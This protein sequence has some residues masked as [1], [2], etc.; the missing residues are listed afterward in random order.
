MRSTVLYTCNSPFIPVKQNKQYY[1][2]HN[3]DCIPK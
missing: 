1:K 3:Y 2:V